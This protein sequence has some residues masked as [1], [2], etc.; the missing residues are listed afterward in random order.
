MIS[1]FFEQRLPPLEFPFLDYRVRSTALRRAHSIGGYVPYHFV[2]KE[3][4]RTSFAHD[5]RSETASSASGEHVWPDTDDEDLQKGGRAQGSLHTGTLVTLPP[6]PPLAPP[7][8]P[9][10]VPTATACLPFVLASAAP[11]SVPPR[12]PAWRVG[13]V[14]AALAVSPQPTPLVRAIVPAPLV[15]RA[16]SSQEQVVVEGKRV[17]KEAITTLL[18]QNLP[19]SLS[20]RELLRELDRSGFRGLYDFV[21]LP[22]SRKGS[23]CHGSAIVNFVSVAVAG[24]F[25]GAWQR[26]RRCGMQEHMPL[27]SISPADAQ[28]QGANVSNWPELSSGLRIP[29][30]PLVQL[31][32]AGRSERRSCSPGVGRER[33]SEVVAAALVQLQAQ[34]EVP[35]DP[36]AQTEEAQSPQPQVEPPIEVQCSAHVRDPNFFVGA[37]TQPRQPAQSWASLQDAEDAECGGAWAELADAPHVAHEGAAGADLQEPRRDSR[38]MVQGAEGTDYASDRWPAS[39]TTLMIRNL[40]A[41]ATQRQLLAELDRTG[42]EGQYDFVYIPSISFKARESKGYGFVNFC[43]QDGALAFAKTWHRSRCCNVRADM[44]ALN[45][46]PAAVQGLAANTEK[47]AGSRMARIR[48]ASLRPYLRDRPSWTGSNGA[49]GALPAPVPT[50]GFAMGEP[51][52]VPAGLPLRVRPPSPQWE[53]RGLMLRRMGHVGED[54]VDM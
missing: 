51:R 42:F 47:W 6:A 2:A 30:P 53:V 38:D 21:A 54:M 37:R 45:I 19:A 39:T 13:A 27:L 46:S 23:P 14:A 16:C 9:P 40:P 11:P 50:T 32:L 7:L 20:Q 25:I 10:K 18:I 33:T 5:N 4:R 28:G 22:T 52:T 31:R 3:E 48:N 29:E 41:E 34:V 15:Q 17:S 26:S 35:P 24:A 8:A 49:G 36:N 44:P 43:S 1:S 12:V